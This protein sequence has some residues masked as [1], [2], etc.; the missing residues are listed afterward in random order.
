MKLTIEVFLYMLFFFFE[1]IAIVITCFFS[2]FTLGNDWSTYKFI[3][4]SLIGYILTKIFIIL[5]LSLIF[6]AI[7]TLL[8]WLLK[9]FFLLSDNLL[10]SLNTF[11][12]FKWQFLLLFCLGFCAVVWNTI[13]ISQM[14]F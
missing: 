11:K 5:I 1:I 7:P 4:D 14:K 6:G 3:N 13:R 8:Y 2:I 12:F 9:K 10:N